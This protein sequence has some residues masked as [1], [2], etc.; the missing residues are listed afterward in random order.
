RP[1]PT[2]A[3]PDRYQNVSGR[4]LRDLSASGPDAQLVPAR[5]RE[6]EPAAT[7]E[8]VRSLDDGAAGRGDRRGRHVEVVGEQQ[9]QGAGASWF[10][11]GVETARLAVARG[12]A[13]T[14]VVGA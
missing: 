6:V 7:R 3:L 13:D 4:R 10:A 5:V 8:L 1:C 2:T 11:V 12:G 14:G 9:D